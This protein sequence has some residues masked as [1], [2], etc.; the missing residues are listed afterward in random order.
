MP[1]YVVVS[2]VSLGTPDD[3]GNINHFQYEQG[4]RVTLDEE[5]GRQYIAD[6]ALRELTDEEKQQAQESSKSSKSSG[7][8]G[9]SG[10]AKDKS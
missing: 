3:R 7:D 10:G 5:V 4:Q 8:T 1:E 9:S 2:R 6:G